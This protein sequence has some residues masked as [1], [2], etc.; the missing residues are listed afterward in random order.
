[1]AI[2]QSHKHTGMQTIV[3]AQ[4][5]IRIKCIQNGLSAFTA[6]IHMAEMI[7]MGEEGRMESL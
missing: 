5:K 4:Q 2:K 3:I 7:T 6:E 1:M